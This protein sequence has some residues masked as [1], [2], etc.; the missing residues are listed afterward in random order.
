MDILAQEARKRQ[1]IVRLSRR[2]G[3]C[4]AARVYG[5]SLSSIKRWDKR[6]DGKDWRSFLEK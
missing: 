5:V 4:F 6:Y 2:K 3:K 1:A